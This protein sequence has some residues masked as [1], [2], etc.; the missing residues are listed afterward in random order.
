MIM[1]GLTGGSHDNYVADTAREFQNSYTDICVYNYALMSDQPKKEQIK[2]M[3]NLKFVLEDLKKKYRKIHCIGF[4][5]GANQ[6]LYYVGRAGEGS[7]VDRAAVV[8]NPYDLSVCSRML[9]A[10]ADY[11]LTN[12]LKK[13]IHRMKENFAIFDINWDNVLK[14]NKLTELDEHFTIKV[15]G[16]QTVSDYYRSVSSAQ[17]V[18]NV[19][20]PV[21][22][23]S[24]RDDEISQYAAIK[25]SDKISYLI[26]DKGGHNAFLDWRLR[27]WF[28]EPLR[29]FMTMGIQ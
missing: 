27:F 8:S 21:L 18:N 4:S 29:E 20:I 6:L 23:I 17:H 11:G 5:Y 1:P 15:Y 12:M 25:F 7:V 16:F 28:L 2:I 13:K 26:T 10:V 22:S 19:S 14:S 9:G 3:E 24:S